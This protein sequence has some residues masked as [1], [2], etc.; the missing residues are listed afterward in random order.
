MHHAFRSDIQRRFLNPC[1][2]DRTR[3]VTC[4][5]TG[6]VTCRRAGDV[7]PPMGAGHHVLPVTV[8]EPRDI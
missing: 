5:R 1:G 3:E 7:S 8:S 2:I 6:E 4:R